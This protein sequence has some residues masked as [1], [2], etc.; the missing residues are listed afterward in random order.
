MNKKL[1]TKSV[2]KYQASYKLTDEHIQGKPI[3]NVALYFCPYLC[4]L[5]TDFQNSFTGTL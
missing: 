4:Q 2:I 1:R 3:K 5:L